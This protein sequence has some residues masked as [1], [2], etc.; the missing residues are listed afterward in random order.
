[1]SVVRRPR[2]EDNVSFALGRCRSPP[3]GTRTCR[4]ELADGAKPSALPDARNGTVPKR[5]VSEGSSGELTAARSAARLPEDAA[6][7]APE[8]AAHPGWC[9]HIRMVAPV[10]AP[11]PRFARNLKGMPAHPEPF[12]QHGRSCMS[13][14]FNGRA[15]RVTNEL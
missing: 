14:V 12:K 7:G 4:E 6:R 1:M 5:A 13:A 9:A 2:A 3:A 8:G 11:H 10:G 15:P